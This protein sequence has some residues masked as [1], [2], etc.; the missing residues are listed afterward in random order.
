MQAI[1]LCFVT[2]FTKKMATSRQEKTY[3]E[4]IEYYNF[5]DQLIKEVEDSKHELAEKQF[6][7]VEEVVEKLEDCA[8]KLTSDY[9]EYVKNGESDKMLQT[10]R[11]T[12][13]EIMS[14]IEECK[15]KILLL[16]SEKDKKNNQ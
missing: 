8:D 10:V 12:L 15:S 9:I 14:K 3:N 6:A 1:Y 2:K 11:L 16:Y 4:I 13:N 7:I 5:A